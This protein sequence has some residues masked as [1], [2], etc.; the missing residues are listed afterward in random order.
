MQHS[1]ILRVRSKNAHYVLHNCTYKFPRVRV[2]LG[3]LH[4]FTRLFVC[5]QHKFGD[6][7]LQINDLLELF[8]IKLGSRS[9]KRQFLKVPN[10]FF[11]MSPLE[12]VGYPTQEL[13][14]LIVV[15]REEEKKELVAGHVRSPKNALLVVECLLELLVEVLYGFVAKSVAA[16]HFRVVVL[17][18]SVPVQK[19]E[20]PAKCAIL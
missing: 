9:S 2:C 11:R 8:Q 12:P 3:L 7:L 4:G 14:G 16:A 6:V 15:A 19:G 13:R 10:S 1:D 18:E 20:V 5:Q 17:A